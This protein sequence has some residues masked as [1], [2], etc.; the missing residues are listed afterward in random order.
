[1]CGLVRFAALSWL[2][3]ALSGYAFAV[4][5]PMPAATTRV[6]TLEISVDPRIE[7]VAAVSYLA[8]GREGWTPRSESSYRTAMKAWAEPHR[9]HPAVAR[10]RA[11]EGFAYSYPAQAI[12]HFGPPPALEPIE[13]VPQDAIDA[14]GGRRA[15]DAWVRSLRDFARDTRYMAFYRT[16]QPRFDKMIVRARASIGE[17]DIV[18]PFE[19]FYGLSPQRY[20]LILAPNI[21]AGAFGPNVAL[22]DGRRHFYNIQGAAGLVDDVLDFGEPASIA[23]L[24][25]HE[26][27]HTVVNTLNAAQSAKLDSSASLYETIAE[28]MRAAAYTTWPIAAN[29]ALVRANTLHLC[30]TVFAGG[31]AIACIE[32]QLTN[33]KRFD[34]YVYRIADF[35]AVYY[36]RNRGKWPTYADFHPIDLQVLAALAASER[37]P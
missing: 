5:A 20:S 1:M 2:L 36:E 35:R 12:V 16:Q 8:G 26:F 21:L 11:I 24:G 32:S 30:R 13:P 27:G 17:V 25:W 28:D 29:E 7:L 33:S 22:P 3:W 6:N 14:I 4:E 10:F 23:S 37:K 34:S 31:D 19:R 15:M 18:G 9:S